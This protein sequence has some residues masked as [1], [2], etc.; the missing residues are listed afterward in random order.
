MAIMADA[1]YGVAGPTEQT[2][3]EWNVLT[4]S[5]LAEHIADVL[6]IEEPR[7]SCPFTRKMVGG[8]GLEPVTPCL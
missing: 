3:R 5:C 2:F 1:G 8:T 7:S 6:G 4:A